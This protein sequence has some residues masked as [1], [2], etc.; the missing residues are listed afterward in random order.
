MRNKI[1]T[2]Y[3][4]IT[5]SFFLRANSKKSSI[6]N[7]NS[8]IDKKFERN[9]LKFKRPYGEKPVTCVNRLKKLKNLA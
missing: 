9:F 2:I 1:G 7:F 6:Y 4:L 3:K 8:K 5:N